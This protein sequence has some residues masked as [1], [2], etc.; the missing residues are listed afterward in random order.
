M[1]DILFKLRKFC[2]K[3][4]DMGCEKC[5]IFDECHRMFDNSML[6]FEWTDTDIATIKYIIQNLGEK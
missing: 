6:P 2:D 3:R 5:P 4:F 1:S